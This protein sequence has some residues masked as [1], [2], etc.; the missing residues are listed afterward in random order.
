MLE[1]QRSIYRN[2]AIVNQSLLEQT[3]KDY[4][5]KFVST[6]HTKTIGLTDPGFDISSISNPHARL[7]AAH[8]LLWSARYIN[9]DNVLD[10]IDT[11]WLS[12]QIK[13]N[14]ISVIN[15]F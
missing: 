5:K 8:A 10:L 6:F 2:N 4:S 11:N 13:N 7:T 1:H 15:D 12:N 14:M 3:F 9:D